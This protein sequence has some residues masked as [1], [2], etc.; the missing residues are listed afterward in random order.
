MDLQRSKW[1]TPENFAASYKIWEDVHVEVGIA[2]M[3][4]DYNPE[5]KHSERVLFHAGELWRSA[6]FDETHLEG[7]TGNNRRNKSEATVT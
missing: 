7:T 4:P 2:Y 1:T 6:S 5:E 3:N